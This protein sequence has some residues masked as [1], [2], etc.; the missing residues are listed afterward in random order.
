M[1]N[2]K[3]V[4]LASTL[5]FLTPACALEG[6]DPYEPNDSLATATLVALPFR[7]FDLWVDDADSDYFEFTVSETADVRVHLSFLDADGDVDLR[8][9][10]A[11]GNVIRTSASTSD[12]EEILATVPAGTYFVEVHVFGFGANDYDIVIEQR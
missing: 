6:A 10:D 2:W 12:E 8:L 11:S 4:A 9:L 5:T 3:Y 7:D 1:K